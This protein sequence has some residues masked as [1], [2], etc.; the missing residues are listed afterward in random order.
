MSFACTWLVSRL[1]IYSLAVWSNF[2][3]DLISRYV[4]WCLFSQGVPDRRRRTSMA[5]IESIGVGFSWRIACGIRQ[6][7][8]SGYRVFALR[9]HTSSRGSRGAPGI[10]RWWC[11]FVTDFHLCSAAGILTNAQS[12]CDRRSMSYIM[13]NCTAEW[14]ITTLYLEW[15]IVKTASS[16]TVIQ[17]AVK[18]FVIYTVKEA[19]MLI[20]GRRFLAANLVGCVRIS[21]QFNIHDKKKIVFHRVTFWLACDKRRQ[22]EWED[23]SNCY[24][25]TFSRTY[26][27]I[28]YGVPHCSKNQVRVWQLMRGTTITHRMQLPRRKEK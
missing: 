18:L 24:M 10:G 15:R 2:R 5:S 28:S 13:A 22:S 27:I 1:G 8:S 11:S 20:G 7:C 16:R 21:H 26:K 25:S 3:N 19:N 12:R 4:N 14:Q 17:P 6:C 9:R 23:P